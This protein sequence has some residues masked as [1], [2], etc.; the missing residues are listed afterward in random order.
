MSFFGFGID[1]NKPGPGIPKNTPE[2]KG[3]ALFFDIFFREFWGLLALNLIYIAACVPLVTIGPA[4]AAL[5]RVTITMVRDQNVYVWRD[6]WN[7]FR[8]NLKQGILFGIPATLF[9]VTAIML[10]ITL[11][12]SPDASLPTSA[13]LYFWTFLGVAIGCYIFPL[14]AYIDLPSATLLK[15]SVLLLVL[16]KF[17]TIAATLVSIA[18]AAA[19]VAFFPFSLPVIMLF[20]FFA[21]L[22]IFTMFMVWPVIAKFAIARE[23]ASPPQNSG[24][25][26]PNP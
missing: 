1:Y 8:K 22:S 25:E 15:N 18:A 10:N 21:F 17:R 26:S 16:G 19:V 3:A 23:D 2:K 6:F 20:G 7:A 9:V 24:S 4:T 12:L 11:L 14:V 5:C 13:F